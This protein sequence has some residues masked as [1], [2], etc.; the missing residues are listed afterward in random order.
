MPAGLSPFG[1]GGGGGGAAGGGAPGAGGLG[2]GGGGGLDPSGSAPTTTP[3]AG[4]SHVV[5][6]TQRRLTYQLFCAK[7]GIDRM[8]LLAGGTPPARGRTVAAGGDANAQVPA[9]AQKIAQIR[10]QVTALMQAL[11]DKSSSGRRPRGKAAAVAE[12]L[13]METLTEDLERRLPQLTKLLP[14]TADEPE[15]PSAPGASPSPPGK[16][17]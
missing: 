2:P 9:A 12:P 7:A 16:K 5:R 1:P 13:T 10:D 3:T 8:Y 11:Q 15:E 14:K 4:P 17:A 6:I